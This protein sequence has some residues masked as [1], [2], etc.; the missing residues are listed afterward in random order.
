VAF[1]INATGFLQ[2][3]KKSGNCGFEIAKVSCNEFYENLFF[4][5]PEGKF[6]RLYLGKAP[7]TIYISAFVGFTTL[8]GTL[9]IKYGATEIDSMIIQ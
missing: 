9:M 3:F 8:Q 2:Y 7:G 6:V 5:N 4:D 1:L